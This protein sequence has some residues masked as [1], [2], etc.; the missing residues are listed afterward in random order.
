VST[1]QASTQM[2]CNIS[3]GRPHD[4]VLML[5]SAG[6]TRQFSFPAREH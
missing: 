1:A 6:D 2:S 5:D 3:Y 4:F